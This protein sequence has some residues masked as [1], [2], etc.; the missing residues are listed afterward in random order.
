MEQ[1]F[2][3]NYY[4]GEE[5]DQKPEFENLEEELGPWANDNQPHCEDENFNVSNI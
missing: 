4:A 5:G 1:L 2:N 3:D